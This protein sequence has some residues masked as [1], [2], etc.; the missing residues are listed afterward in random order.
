MV[1]VLAVATGLFAG[2]FW[3][4]W[5]GQPYMV[6]Q[7]EYM[8][9]V[10]VAFLPQFLLIYLPTLSGHLPDWLIAICLLASQLLFFGFVWTNR[11]LSGMSFLLGGLIMNLAV[12]AVNSGFMPISPQIA[13]RLVSREV[14]LDVSLGGRF[15]TK[16][17]LL[18]P[19]DTRL[20]W[21][22][23]RF[24]PPAWSPYQVAFSLGDV[25]VATGA[26]W[27]L[28][29]QASPPTRNNIGE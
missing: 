7:L 6:P 11:R 9:L 15:G 27:L 21:L 10:F 23:D 17:I 26:F 5:R 3:A 13:G 18:S 12:M 2:L 4:H 14:L 22:A 16:D 19:Q 1:L 29:K 25:L 20:E 28:A 8:W 24:L